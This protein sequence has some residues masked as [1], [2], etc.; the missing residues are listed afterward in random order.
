MYAAYYD[1]TGSAESVLKTGELQKPYAKPGEV[2]VHMASSG[3]NPSDTKKRAGT[4]TV[5]KIA[6]RIIP[7]SDGAGIIE[8]VGS[9][10]DAARIGERVWL[11]NAQWQRP[12]GTAAEWCAVPAEQ[13]VTLPEHISFSAAACLG[14]P[15]QTAWIALQAGLEATGKTILVQGGAGAVGELAVQIAV[16]GGARVLATVSTQEKAAIAERAGAETIN[17]RNADSVDQI[18]EMTS[19]EGVDHIVEVDF[20]ANWKIDAAVLKQNGSVSAYSSPSDAKF[21]LDY[22]AFAAKAAHLRFVQVYLLAPAERAKCL[23]SITDLLQRQRLSIRVAKSFTLESI[24]A[25]HQLQESGTT[26][27][28]I[29]VDIDAGIVG[30]KKSLRVK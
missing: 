29:V 11:W 10:V 15:A 3:V 2:L 7:H 26:I 4:M 22:Y 17:Y 1:K 6:D 24:V 12:Q 25:A 21:E 9:G 23:L 16:D 13:A 5:T 18:L 19:G 30:P 28:N 27:G 20:G 14:I 8:A